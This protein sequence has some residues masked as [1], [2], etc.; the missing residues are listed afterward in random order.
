MDG[1]D[2]CVGKAAISIL[3][4]VLAVAVAPTPALGMISS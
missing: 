3:A 2:F 4:A 1:A